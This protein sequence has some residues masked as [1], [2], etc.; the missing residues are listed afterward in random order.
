VGGR[1]GVNET[2]ITCEGKG[3]RKEEGKYLMMFLFVGGG[4]GGSI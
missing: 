3:G 2:A 4:E 1:K